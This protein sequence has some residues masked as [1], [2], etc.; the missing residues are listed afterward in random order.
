MNWK[1]ELHEISGRGLQQGNYLKTSPNY[2][3]EVAENLFQ[4]S[5]CGPSYESWTTRKDIWKYKVQ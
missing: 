3:W 2:L 4:C 1:A 5:V